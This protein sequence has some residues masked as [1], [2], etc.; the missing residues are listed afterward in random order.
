MLNNEEMPVGFVM[1]LAKHSD[2]LV[3]FSK[4]PESEQRAI[5]NQAR[6]AQSKE[7]MSH[8]VESI[9]PQT[10]SANMQV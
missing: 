9:S 10:H 2:I 4:L 8:L 1:E 7:E 6:N 3:H 5:I